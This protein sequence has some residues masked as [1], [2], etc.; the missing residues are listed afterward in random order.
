MLLCIQFGFAQPLTLKSARTAFQYA[1]FNEKVALHFLNQYNA[2]IP[3]LVGFEGYHGA[4]KMIMAKHVYT[5]WTKWMY[6]SEGKKQLEEAISKDPGNIELIYLR[7]CIQSNTPAFLNYNK[8]IHQD[9]KYLSKQVHL[10]LDA[11]LKNR[12]KD[13]LAYLEKV[14]PQNELVLS[15]NP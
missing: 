11:S 1:P 9:R 12:I 13:Y 10:I 4:I 15:N 14:L 2:H 6:F 7:L 5:P 8:N 3:K